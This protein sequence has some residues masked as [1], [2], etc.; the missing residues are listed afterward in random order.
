MASSFN[1]VFRGAAGTSSGELPIDDIFNSRI[2]T[3]NGGTQLITTG[4]DM[5]QGGMVW[6]ARLDANGTDRFLADTNNGTI[7][8]NNVNMLYPSASDAIRS[9]NSNHSWETTGFKYNGG[10]N[11]IYNSNSKVYALWS[12]RKSSKF[13]TM[14]N[15]TGTGSARTVAHDLGAVPGCIFVKS[16]D[17]SQS[18]SVYHKG[19]NE[20]TNPHLYGLNLDLEGHKGSGTDDWNDTAPTDSV[21]SVGTNA[22]VNAD[23]TNYT[24][25][26]FG[27]DTDRETGQI[28]AGHYTGSDSTVSVTIGW[29][30]Q[31]LL[32]KSDTETRNWTIVDIA[33][34]MNSDTRTI[35]CS[36]N[37]DDE[38]NTRFNNRIEP[39]TDGFV[40]FTE[41]NSNRETRICEPSQT[42]TYLA[43]RAPMQK[44]PTLGTDV[45]DVVARQGTG[46]S[47][48]ITTG[49][50]R[51][52]LLIS[53]ARTIG[54]GLGEH[55]GWVDRIRG[56]KFSQ[57]PHQDNVNTTVD[58]HDEG[59][60]DDADAFNQFS[61]FKLGGNDTTYGKI[62]TSGVNFVIHSMKRAKGFLDILRYT[63]TGSARTQK[64]NLGVTPELMIIKN[65]DVSDPWIV[66]YGDNTDYLILNTNVDTED[67]NTVWNDTSPTEAVFTVGTNHGVNANGESYMA[68]LFA[69]V[70]GVSKIG[71]YTGSGSD[72]DVDCGFANGARFVMIKR[73][74]SAGDWHVFNSA[75]GIIAGNDPFLRFNTSAAESTGSDLIDPLN[76]G[77]TAVNGTDVN[78]SGGSYVFLAID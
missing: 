38:F 36:D 46:G 15:Y 70:A 31:W 68:Y 63:G 50:E 54:S 39:R 51:V 4:L 34:G 10:D 28:A 13:F 21:F 44:L 26:I 23:G 65:N 1:Q 18:W 72:I 35:G 42:F 45:Y 62:N 8:S 9:Y 64:H 19:I 17:D 5:T 2:Y 53:K 78:Q 22:R 40:V 76:A 12:F 47:A 60:L 61:G 49:I 20:S 14:I 43:I 73:I 52:D 77:F 32:I 30:P 16:I 7:G 55:W 69:T 6:G 29:E 24:A 58:S 48:V 25:Y 71:T 66:Y 27:H 41:G 37:K 33:R 56:P 57:T 59:G 67:D 3:G 74:N 75:R 11:V